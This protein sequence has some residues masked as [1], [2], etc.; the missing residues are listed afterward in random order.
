[1]KSEYQQAQDWWKELS[2]KT[3]LF[4]CNNK[5][6]LVKI[7]TGTEIHIIYKNQKK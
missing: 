4:Y 3:K 2:Y 7:L 6:E 5:P 1:M